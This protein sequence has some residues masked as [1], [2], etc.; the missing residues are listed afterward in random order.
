MGAGDASGQEAGD[1]VTLGLEMVAR[2]RP[3]VYGSEVAIEEA[4]IHR[5]KNE[6]RQWEHCGFDGGRRLRRWLASSTLALA[7]HE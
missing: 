3:C 4:C 7:G 2:F 5:R 6:K 1:V